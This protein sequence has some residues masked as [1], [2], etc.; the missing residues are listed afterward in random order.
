MKLINVLSFCKSVQNR[1]SAGESPTKTA[2]HDRKRQHLDVNIDRQTRGTKNLSHSSDV[3]S[4]GGGGNV[5]GGETAGKISIIL[6]SETAGASSSPALDAEFLQARHQH[7][8]DSYGADS[9]LLSPQR[10]SLVRYPS[11]SNVTDRSNLTTD[12][13]ISSK[14]GAASDWEFQSI[15]PVTISSPDDRSSPSQSETPLSKTAD[16]EEDAKPSIENKESNTLFSSSDQIVLANRRNDLNLGHQRRSPDF[17][18]VQMFQRRSD[19]DVD[20]SSTSGRTSWME[21]NS[22][23]SEDSEVIVRTS[24]HLRDV[25][26]ISSNISFTESSRR[27]FC[28]FPNRPPRRRSSGAAEKRPNT[29]RGSS[30]GEGVEIILSRKVSRNER[31]ASKVLG[32]ILLAFVVFWTPFF[33]VNILSVVCG[34]CELW[35]SPTLTTYVVWWG[36]ASSLANPVIYTLFSKSFR[37]AFRRILACRYH[38]RGSRRRRRNTGWHNGT[39]VRSG[40]NAQ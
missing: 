28:C 39:K 23:I 21:S 19:C 40:S 26:R 12:K 5:E 18:T 36:Y 22:S 31:K 29:A 30:G 14:G 33:A 4:C 6:T 34:S 1:F 17:L 27:G 16:G 9:C 13:M 3:G 24:F 7:A 15:P 11:A 10:T 37:T 38:H 25:N 32:I 8:A 20:A 35:L 2:T